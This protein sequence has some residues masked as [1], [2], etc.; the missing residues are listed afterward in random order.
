MNESSLPAVSVES[1]KA[2]LS[3]LPAHM[4]GRHACVNHRIQEVFAHSYGLLLLRD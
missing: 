2:A 4:R 1:V 3:R